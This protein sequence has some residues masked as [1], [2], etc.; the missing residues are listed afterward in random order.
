MQGR[1]YIRR[2][3][4]RTPEESQKRPAKAQFT[5]RPWGILIGVRG[6]WEIGDFLR[7]SA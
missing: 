2:N 3:T 5:L 7:A 1:S 6:Y 4:K